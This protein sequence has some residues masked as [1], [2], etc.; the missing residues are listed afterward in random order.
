MDNLAEL[1]AITG[2]TIDSGLIQ[3]YIEKLPETA[4]RF[5]IRV[6]LALLVFFIGTW[7]I[8]WVCKILRKSMQRGNADI[9]ATQFLTS[10]VRIS[11]YVVLVLFIAS[12]FG[13]DAASVVAL[14]GSAGVAIGLAV[15]GS[16]SNLAGGILILLLK[17][18]KV[19]DYIIAANGNE[20][21]VQEI[22]IFYTKLATADNRMV[23]IPNGDLSNSSMINVS[24]MPDRR[25][26]ISVG[27][28]YQADIRQAREVLMKLLEND[29]Q[30]LQD[31]DKRVFVDSLGESAVILDVRFHVLTADYWECK[32]RM[33]ENIKYALDEAGISIPYNQL[34]VH[35]DLQT[36]D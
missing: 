36:R 12:G 1:E 10:F 7:L 8:K 32:W 11:L 14:L 31:M 15:Q 22:Q 27:I 5:G 21:T 4:L 25:I 28:S 16:L 18:F 9:G 3:S 13:L 2:E 35:L 23:V 19:G 6:V 29:G 20:G 24:A 33:T 17:P 30:V 26:D 34:D